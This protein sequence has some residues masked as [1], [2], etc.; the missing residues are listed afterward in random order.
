MFGSES[1]PT[2]AS[3]TM[4]HM[5]SHLP[6]HSQDQARVPYHMIPIGGIQMVQA[7]PRA[8][9]ERSPSSA[10]SSPTSP[11]ED[12]ALFHATP[13]GTSEMRTQK[14]YKS[15][16]LQ[17]RSSQSGPSIPGMVTTLPSPASLHPGKQEQELDATKRKQHGSSHTSPTDTHSL[18]TERTDA[19]ASSYS[20][21]PEQITDRLS[22]LRV[23][24]FS[25]N[26]RTRQLPERKEPPSRRGSSLAEREEEGGDSASRRDCTLGDT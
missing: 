20:H 18:V 7:R 23:S 17:Q 8:K 22:G 24:S 5:F 6:L 14:D 16:T 4:D 11:K 26:Q 19:Q 25:S 2:G 9:L 3:R 10:A 12:I 1:M 21:A 13:P 15:Q